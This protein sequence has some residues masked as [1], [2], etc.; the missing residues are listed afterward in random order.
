M[1][2]IQR[3]DEVAEANFPCEK[4]LEFM[5]S[6]ADD[7]K[8]L[9]RGDCRFAPTNIMKGERVVRFEVPHGPDVRFHPECVYDHLREIEAS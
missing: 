7:K 9:E 3:F 4:H 8:V 1:E 6:S 5:I 2:G